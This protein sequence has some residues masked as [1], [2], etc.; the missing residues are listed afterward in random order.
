MSLMTAAPISMHVHDAHSIDDAAFVIQGHVTAMTRRHCSR[1]ACSD[2]RCRAHDDR[3]R[4]RHR[5]AIRQQPPGILSGRWAGLCSLTR[6]NLLLIGATVPRADL[7]P[8]ERFR[9]PA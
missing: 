3:R 2:G 5:G 8:A 7:A 1:L 6:L 9:A 4:H